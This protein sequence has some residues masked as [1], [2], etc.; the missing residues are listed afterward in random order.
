[1]HVLIRER[2]YLLNPLEKGER[3]F[4]LILSQTDKTSL[5]AIVGNEEQPKEHSFRIAQNFKIFEDL[6]A[7]SRS[8]LAAVCKDFLGDAGGIE[9]D[10][11]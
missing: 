6:I 1:M 3:K 4:K 5:I 8:G 10:R 2:Y 11:V 9:V 7:N